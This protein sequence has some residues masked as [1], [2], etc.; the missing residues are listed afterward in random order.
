[1]GRSSGAHAEQENSSKG[2]G[3]RQA[4]GEGRGGERRKGGQES[5]AGEG[6]PP[7]MARDGQGAQPA[8][9]RGPK[10]NTEGSRN[11]GEE[12]CSDDVRACR[13]EEEVFMRVFQL[14][15]CLSCCLLLM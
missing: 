1:M 13:E 2:T 15:L 10:T 8:W 9:V 6:R 14:L 5:E 11:P 4:K 7:G 12:L 3:E